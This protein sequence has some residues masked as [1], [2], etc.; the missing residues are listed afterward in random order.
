MTGETI[1]ELTED[2]L[3]YRDEGFPSDSILGRLANQKLRGLVCS[4]L[5]WQPENRPSVG[6]VMLELKQINL[7]KIDSYFSLQPINNKSFE[8]RQTFR[9][10]LFDF[11]EPRD[12]TPI[13]LN[14]PKITDNFEYSTSNLTI[15]FTLEKTSSLRQRIRINITFQ[16]K[17][18]SSLSKA[19]V[20]NL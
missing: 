18:N 6:E 15:F 5:E 10:H 9:F 1:L 19:P 16:T 13:D 8:D 2:G 4:M 12:P 14:Y 17:A 7:K 11:K 3:P 20:N